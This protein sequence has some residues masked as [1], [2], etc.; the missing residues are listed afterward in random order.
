MKKFMKKILGAVGA[1]AMLCSSAF[2]SVDINATNFPD[3]RFRSYVSANFDKNSD[4][5]LSD[6]EI[7]QV[8]VIGISAP[9]N[10]TGIEYF[11]SLRLLTCSPYNFGSAGNYKFNYT[12]FKADYGLN[13]DIDDSYVLMI[14]TMKYHHETDKLTTPLIGDVRDTSG[15]DYILNI[16]VYDPTDMLYG[17]GFI[18]RGTQIIEIRVFR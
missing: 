16:P 18:T 1:V 7:N 15:D 4:G 17:I 6:R 8:I 12:K 2:A 5:V 9:M 3:A 14:Y 13:C 11:T 10:L